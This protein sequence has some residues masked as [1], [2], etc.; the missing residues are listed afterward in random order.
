MA[1]PKNRIRKF[2]RRS[3]NGCSTCKQ[4]HVRCDERKPLWYAPLSHLPCPCP[5]NNARAP[6][7]PLVKRPARGG[8]AHKTLLPSNDYLTSASAQTVCRPARTVYIQTLNLMRSLNQVLFQSLDLGPSSPSFRLQKPPSSPMSSQTSHLP[9]SHATTRCR[10]CHNGSGT[11]ASSLLRFRDHLTDTI[12]SHCL[13]R[14]RSDSGRK[15][16]EPMQV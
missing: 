5:L 4:R 11:N 12:P 13:L 15:G 8:P 1:P 6:Q 16:T 2:H 14:Q 3:K 9:A 7:L 10:Q